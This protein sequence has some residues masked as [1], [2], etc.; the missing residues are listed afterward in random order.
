MAY[1]YQDPK[2]KNLT[3]WKIGEDVWIV[4]GVW[5]TAD[6]DNGRNARTEFIHLTPVPPNKNQ[7]L[8]ISPNDLNRK[9]PIR[10]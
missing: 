2:Y 6:D 7:P 8:K 5:S 10:V 3:K 4:D 1:N 9:N